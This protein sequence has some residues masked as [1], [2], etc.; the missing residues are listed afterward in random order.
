MIFSLKYSVEILLLAC[1]KNEN[2]IFK[3]EKEVS[4]N[5]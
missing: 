3:T 5:N 2:D 1:L 4:M